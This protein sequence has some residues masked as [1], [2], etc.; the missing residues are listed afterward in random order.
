MQQKA[1]SILPYC[2]DMEKYY[3]AADFMISASR[4]EAFPKVVQEG[5]FYSL[6]MILAPVFGIIEQV[7]DEVSA[8]FF[9]PGDSKKLA[10][11]IS[12][13][14]R[15][16]KL[17]MKLAQNARVSLNRLP[18]MRDMVRDYKNII[19]EAWLSG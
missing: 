4:I 6:P 2:Q 8:L 9:S 3:K 7:Q 16:S 13:I 11:K 15:D 5:M 1:I 19:S 18:S 17:R 10:E 12:R 14:C